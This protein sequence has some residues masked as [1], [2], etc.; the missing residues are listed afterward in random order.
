MI[1]KDPTATF[2]GVDDSSA[3]PELQKEGVKG[4]AISS[5]EE[6]LFLTR[7]D[8]FKLLAE[9]EADDE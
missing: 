4:V 5:T 3:Y 8:L 7:S 1:L 2:E 9:L 6:T